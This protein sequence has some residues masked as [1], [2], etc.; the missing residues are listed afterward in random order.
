M[1][2]NTCWQNYL[3][4]KSSTTMSYN[5]DAGSA[6]DPFTQMQDDMR[7]TWDKL[8]KSARLTLYQLGYAEGFRVSTDLSYQIAKTWKSEQADKK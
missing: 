7:A 1:F 2:C 4:A 5:Y 3:T 8:P 6:K